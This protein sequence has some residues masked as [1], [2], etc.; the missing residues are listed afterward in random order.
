M[1]EKESHQSP[2]VLDLARDQLHDIFRAL[3]QA[4]AA[5]E[6]LEV[7]F[8]QGHITGGIYRS[9]GQE[10]GAVGAAYALRRRYDGTGD[11]IAPTV[12]ATGAVFLLGGTPLQ[13]FREYLARATSPTRGR[14]S[15]VYWAD[16]ET[17]LVGPTS[18]LG[19]MVEVM[20]GVSLAFKLKEEDRVALVFYGDGASS[21]GAWHEGLCFAAAQACPM[22]LIVEANQWAFSSPTSTNTRVQ[23][24]VEK[25]PGY[26]LHAESV[27]GTDVLAVYA[28]VQRAVARAR[29]GEGAGM[30]ELKYYRLAG[31]AQHDDLEYVD[32]DELKKWEDRDPI[33]RFRDRLLAEEW[34]TGD[35]LD[36]LAD[37]TFEE[38]RS[39]AD[40]A[41]SESAPEGPAA[42]DDVY[43]DLVVRPPWTRMVAPDPRKM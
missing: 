36:T 30:V 6:R 29:G 13:F 15:K 21:T 17:G 41:L 22:V 37:D 26:G 39:A 24:F 34:A 20:S 43:T 5:E 25:A 10:A 31:H 23:S 11:I 2:V 12:R 18:T 3:V 19:T 7:L 42:L 28:C 4:R 35:E 1:T 40:Q 38:A 14:E 16:Y 9:L 8:K 33:A 32:P 27:D